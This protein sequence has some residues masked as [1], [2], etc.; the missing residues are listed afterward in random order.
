MST[1]TVCTTC[2][3]LF[4][5]HHEKRNKGAD[6]DEEKA[7]DDRAHND[8]YTE[9]L[10]TQIV[11]YSSFLCTILPCIFRSAIAFVSAIVSTF[12]CT[13][14]L[15]I[16]ILAG[17]HHV[18]IIVS[19]I[20]GIADAPVSTGQILTFTVPAI[21]LRILTLV[22]VNG[23][24]R[25]GVSSALAVARKAIH[26]I[27]TLAIILAGHVTF[28][29]RR[30][31]IDIDLAIHAGVTGRASAFRRLKVQ[32]VASSAILAFLTNTVG[33]IADWTVVTRH[34]ITGEV[35]ACLRIRYVYTSSAVLTWFVLASNKSK[36]LA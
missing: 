11:G 10:A 28:N 9:N 33:C 32:K 22:H 36:A 27:I 25:T 21:N 24:M 4:S 30:A 12:T 6:S 7:T 3:T 20:A 8:R 16:I 14:V 26:F 17:I 18:A 1:R 19:A 31:I 13:A 5:R 23:A 29:I 2:C 15:A 34:A 35:V